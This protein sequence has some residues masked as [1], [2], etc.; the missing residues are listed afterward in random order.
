MNW[1]YLTTSNDEK[2]LVNANA[3]MSIKYSKDTDLTIIDYV[4]SAYPSTFVRGNIMMD[5]KRVLNS[6]DNWVTQIGE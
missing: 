4:R 2:I 5:I 6:H 3:I 1:F